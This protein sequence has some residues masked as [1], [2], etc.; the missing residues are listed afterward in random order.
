MTDSTATTDRPANRSDRLLLPAT[1]AVSIL[2]LVAL[3]FA[4]WFG[5]GW[6]Q[7]GFS[8]KPRADAREAALDGA[9]QAAINLTSM[10]PDDVE[11]S[12][13]TMESSSTGDMLNQITE[14]RAKL[15]QAATDSKSK[16]ESSVLGASLTELNTDD[17]TA[18]ALI[19]LSQTTTAPNQAPSKQRITWT[20]SLQ[21]AD[22]T[23]KA[24]QATTL[25]APVVLDAPQVNQPP[26]APA[27]AP[28]PEGQP[29]P[30]PGGP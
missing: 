7:A 16:L 10:N 17:D 3:V 8:E 29:A 22:G 25:G 4:G 13:K 21:N 27:P 6:A 14:N 9:R 20:L 18:K 28:A 1:I 5:Y 19:V 24:A 15:V 12:V 11:G 26:A 23:W 30:A 2:L